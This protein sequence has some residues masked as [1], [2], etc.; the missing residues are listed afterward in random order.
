MESKIVHLLH[1]PWTGLGLYNGFR[2]NNWL[3]NRIKIFKQF[4]IPSLQAQTNKNFVLWCAF[5]PEEKS[6]PYVKEL[7]DYLSNIQEFKSVFTFHGICFYDDKYEDNI[8]RERLI[9]S[10]HGSIGELLDTIGEV[11]YV[12]MT[13]QP[14]DDLYYSEAIDEIQDVLNDR[15]TNACGY[16]KGYI[17]NYQTKEV[18]EYNPKTN[19]PFYTIKFKRDVFT[20]PL[21]HLEY[22]GIKHNYYNTRYEL[23]TP[24]PSHEYLKDVFGDGYKPINKRGFLVGTHGVN[25][26]T[27]FNIPYAGNMVDESVLEWFGLENVD[28][29]K[30]KISLGKRIILKMPHKIQRKIRYWREKLNV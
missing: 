30:I 2:G 10:L 13:I 6:N 29:L 28:K 25:I 24:L 5:R 27:H 26:S 15:N 1:C 9:M 7:Q 8:A 18:K 11:D 4:V 23:G 16:S 19:P 3:K 12:Y 17:A 20:D 21:K 22:T 14:S